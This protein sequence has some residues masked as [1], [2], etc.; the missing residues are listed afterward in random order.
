MRGGG[1]QAAGLLP[2]AS[3]SQ[4]ELKGQ[5][6]GG[7]AAAAQQQAEVNDEGEEGGPDIGAVQDVPLETAPHRGGGGPPLSSS[8]T[9]SGRGFVTTSGASKS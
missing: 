4:G 5:G 8:P 3:P 7:L 1:G 9:R 6:A 2:P